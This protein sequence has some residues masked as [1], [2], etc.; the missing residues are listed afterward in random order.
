MCAVGNTVKFVFH[1]CSEGITDV[2]HAKFLRGMNLQHHQRL[3]EQENAELCR[4]I[5]DLRWS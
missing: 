3:L 1:F 5:H 2:V 4:R